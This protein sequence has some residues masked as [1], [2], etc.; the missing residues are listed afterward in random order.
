MVDI[1]CLI[2][3]AKFGDDRW[4]GVKSC[5]FPLTL[6]VVLTTLSHY[7]ASVSYTYNSG[8]G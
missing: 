3:H 4:R 2:T 1:S 5:L 7:G 6:M 8:T